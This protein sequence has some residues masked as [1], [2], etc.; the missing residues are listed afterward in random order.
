MRTSRKIS[1][2]RKRKRKKRRKRRKRRRIRKSLKRPRSLRRFAK[3]LSMSRRKGK[4][5]NHNHARKSGYLS[6]SRMSRR[7]SNSLKVLSISLTRLTES[8][9][10]MVSYRTWRY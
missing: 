2:A 6:R 8:F 9:L 7:D 1:Q 5:K 4:R 10:L 3:I